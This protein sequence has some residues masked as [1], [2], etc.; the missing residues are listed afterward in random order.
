MTESGTE[1][2]WSR[3]R[4]TPSEFMP[5]GEDPLQFLAAGGEAGPRDPGP[6]RGAPKAGRSAASGRRRSG[7]HGPAA[8]FWMFGFPVLMVMLVLAIPLLLIAGRRAV[9]DSTDGRELSEVRDPSAPG[10]VALTEPTPTMLLIQSDDK[11][12]PDSLTVMSLT[13][14]GVGGIIFIPIT[15]V[16]DV[17]GVG[18]VPLNVAYQKGGNDALQKG[19]EGLLGVGMAEVAVVTPTMWPDLVGPVGPVAVD[20]PDDVSVVKN[21]ERR[22]LFRKGTVSLAPTDVSTYL[23][24]RNPGESDLNRMVRHKAFWDAW[25][26]KIGTSNNPDAVPGEAESGIGRFVRTLAADRVEM[27]PLPVESR[28]LYGSTDDEFLVPVKEDMQALVAKMVAFPIGAPA[29]A[30]AKVRL[31]DGTGKLDHGLQAAPLII[32]GG[33]QI[34]QVGNAAAFGQATTQ[35]E[36]FDDARLPDVQAIQRALGIGEIVKSTVPGTTAEI[37]ITLG[38]DFAALPVRPLDAAGPTPSSTAKP[39]GTGG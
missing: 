4:Q 37:T 25:L 30:R 12:A 35:L 2:P 27:A 21:G 10:W 18:P 20:N 3:A 23:A 7:G 24:T 9:L 17:P 14:E 8:K 29:G 1:R 22:T 36:Y 38:E 32:K 6:A 39:G 28:R 16:L 26:R 31:L 33:G 34:D 13:G 11:G 15:T 5:S 19:V